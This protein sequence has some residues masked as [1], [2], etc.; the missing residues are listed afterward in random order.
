MVLK[1]AK[2]V[3][4][5]VTRTA[6]HCLAVGLLLLN[7]VCQ[8][9]ILPED[10]ADAMYHS[11]DGGGI[12]IT[13][14]SILVRKQIGDSFSVYGTHYVDTISSA[15]IDVIATAS[16]YAE[17]RTENSI[18]VDYLRDKVTMS[19]AYTNSEEN[20]FHAK[21]LHLGVSQEIFGGM[22]TV[23]LGY[24]RGWDDVGTLGNPETFD[25]DRHNYRLGLSQVLTKDL[26][27]EIGLET[28]TDEGERLNNPYRQVRYLTSA[29]TFDFQDEVYPNT[30]TSNAVSLRAKYFL[31]YRAA[32]H[33]EY[34]WF[35]DTWG[36]TAQNFEIGYT[37]PL[38]DNWTFDVKVRSYKQNEAD[39]YSDL[40]PFQDAQNFL[41]R[42]KEMSS[43]STLTVG[44]GVSYEFG[45]GN[46][47]FIDKGSLNFS[48][49]HIEFEYDNFRDVTAGGTPGS[50]PLYRFDADVVQFFISL[51]Y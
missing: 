46:L 10:R 9:A 20:D 31:P 36:I 48:I 5:A 12:E 14:P 42:D 6:R 33:G 19:L 28:I 13:G 17:E 18:G 39:F 37:Q 35:D 4:V 45:K 27:M 47:G 1:A 21:S 3:D 44:A 24:S 38:K 15:S 26:I 41:A 49:N 7:T 8:A 11:Y 34:R 32:L 29:T 50:E 2:V 51:W 43:F 25:T 23:S 30:R 22:T 40:F 16:P